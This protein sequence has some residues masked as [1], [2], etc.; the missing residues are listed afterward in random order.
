MSQFN[1][2]NA[3]GSYF[4]SQIALSAAEH[5]DV[6][7]V[8]RLHADDFQ[9]TLRGVHYHFRTVVIRYVFK[10]GIPAIAASNSPRIPT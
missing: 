2:V 1:A 3:P 7:A 10:R 6:F 4:A 9:L 5:L 8:F